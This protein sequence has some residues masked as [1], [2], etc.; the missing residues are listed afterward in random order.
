MA[1]EDL[2][3]PSKFIDAFVTGNPVSNDDRREGDDHIRGI[4]NVL[5]NTFPQLNAAVT[6]T[7]EQLNLAAGIAGGAFPGIPVS[8]I[9]D[10][11]LSGHLAVAGDATVAGNVGIGVA[12]IGLRRLCI[13]SEAGIYG[14]W[15][16]SAAGTAYWE[17][18]AA[19][20]ALGFFGS[21]EGVNGAVGGLALRSETFLSLSSG[22]ATERMRIDAAG[23]VGIGAHPYVATAKLTLFDGTVGTLLGFNFAAVS[24]F[25]TYTAHPVAIIANG[26]ERMRVDVAGHVIV[27]AL[28][29]SAIGGGV[30]L[31][32][33]SGSIGFLSQLNGNVAGEMA[34]CNRGAGGMG[35]YVNH[36]SVEAMTILP[37]GEIRVNQLGLLYGGFVHPMVVDPGASMAPAAI[38]I[39]GLVAGTLSGGLGTVYA[40]GQVIT[41]STFFTIVTQGVDASGV[42][43]AGPS[44][45]S[46]NYRL[47]SPQL[48]V[49]VG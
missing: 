27:G 41:L 46:G 5:R 43:Y 30:D 39:G 7:D 37:T 22:G 10:L 9:T 1:L 19:G 33:V 20:A 14:R 35:L 40:P 48:F 15:N 17:I 2:T 47:L 4:K 34:I 29:P 8:G 23:N 26:A 13:D 31:F 45:N 36:A 11:A 18:Y 44:I 32:A 21:T 28:D 3:G 6:A 42:A 25:G 16:A 24:G 38:P 49:R 12:P